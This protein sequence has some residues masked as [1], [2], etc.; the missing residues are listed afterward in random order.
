MAISLKRVALALQLLDVLADD[1]RLLLVVPAAFDLDLVAQLAVGAQRLAEAAFVMRDQTRGRAEDM[2]GRT[3][4]AFEPDDLGAGKVGLE[5]QDV[6]HLGAPPAID[7]LIVVADAANIAVALRQQPQPQILRD[8]G[9]LILVHQHVEEAL[10][11]FRQHV[12]VLL[13]QPQIFQQQI[14]EIGGVELLQAPLIERIELARFAVGEGEAL[15]FRHPLGRKPA[16]LPAV[17]H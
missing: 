5:A 8:V 7:R 10:L 3:V 15:A 11:I 14:A 6:V 13:E 2:A 16:V 1:A 4:V 12:G 17:D 9:V